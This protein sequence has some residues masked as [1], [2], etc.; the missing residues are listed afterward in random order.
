MVGR[1]LLL[2][3]YSQLNYEK[4]AGKKANELNANEYE[5]KRITDHGT[6]RQ[7][8]DVLRARKKERLFFFKERKLERA[9]SLKM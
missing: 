4:N 7:D 5:E 9:Q 8:R 3:F 6:R 2:A 1:Y